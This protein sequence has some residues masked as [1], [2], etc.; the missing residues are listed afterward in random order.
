MLSRAFI[1]FVILVSFLTE[2][3]AYTVSGFVFDRE[4]KEP[5]I[6]ATVYSITEEKG[7]FTNVSGFFSL[8]LDSSNVTL[9][10]EFIGYKDTSAIVNGSENSKLSFL[11]TKDFIH[12]S[13]VQIN[14]D[15]KAFD[16]KEIGVLNIPI[17]QLKDIQILGETDP[18]KIV[19][20]TP[21]VK[22][23]GEGTPGLFVRGSSSDQN[24]YL[25]DDATIYNPFHLFGVYSV[26]NS[27]V[28]KRFKIVKGG[29]SPEYGGRLASVVDMNM[30]DGQKN[31]FG[32]KGTIG[33]LMSKITLESPITKKASFFIS[34][35][36]TYGHLLAKPFVEATKYADFSFYDWY[37][38]VSIQL[39]ENNKLY[40][41]GSYSND[42]FKMDDADEDNDPW[43]KVNINWKNITSSVRW[44]SVLNNKTF[45]STSIIYSRYVL[46]NNIWDKKPRQ[47]SFTETDFY[48]LLYSSKIEDVSLKSSLIYYASSKHELKVGLQITKHAFSPSA[49]ILKNEFVADT[50]QNIALDLTDEGGVY[51]QDKYSINKKVSLN[52]GARASF[53]NNDKPIVNLEPRAVLIVKPNAKSKFE[54]SYTI[55]N[56]YNHLLA[57]KGV[58][59][60][61]DMWVP[62][63]SALPGQR[64]IQYSVGYSYW[65]KK[66]KTTITID[67]YYKEMQNTLAFKEGS[68]FM[69]NE[70]IDNID[71]ADLDWENNVTQ[72][73][74]E[75]SGIE[76]MIHKKKGRFNGW[77][78]YEYSVSTSQ[79]DEINLGRKFY[80][81][82]DHRHNL[83]LVG[84]YNLNEKVQ[85]SLIWTYRTGSPITV[86]NSSYVSYSG[87][88]LQ[89]GTVSDPVLY[90]SG[91]NNYRTPAYHRLDIGMT[92]TKSYKKIDTKLN[93]GVY[94][95]Y[96]RKNIYFYFVSQTSNGQ[97]SAQQVS[98]IPI[99]PNISYEITF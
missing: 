14:T 91:I 25:L 19:Q 78:G 3:S 72:G 62:S 16:K 56:Q 46:D 94:N 33:L 92:Y 80:N 9:S 98:L 48:D 77:I 69:Q 42:E 11:L 27:D 68:T 57:T 89:N 13:A 35:R 82:Y 22:S 41:S 8:S 47:G 74:S 73:A 44:H 83:N 79:F 32:G 21:G 28:L 29:F 30:K 75:A 85:F 96:N 54:A 67:G 64:S 71:A 39:N 53:F 50:E 93:I 15:K 34:G 36:K 6:G 59:F 84:I 51:F 99:I 61:T 52:Y 76:L 17:D 65:I 97:T 90:Y 63:T 86:A 18:L 43:F 60:A 7:V 88:P 2:A 66:L 81:R 4:T 38:K 20:L 26:V 10:C 37:S 31:K 12:I 55:M 24:L 5:I 1:I 58:G 40:L 45:L 87:Q 49:T 70:E 95:V 23:G